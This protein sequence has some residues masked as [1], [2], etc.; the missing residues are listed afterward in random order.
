MLRTALSTLSARKRYVKKH[1]VK[2]KA[3]L[4]S[5][6]QSLLSITVLMSFLARLNKYLY[7]KMHCVFQWS[8]IDSQKE[9]LSLY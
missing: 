9:E 1:T 6:C 5:E 2:M 3:V 4:T 7:L 8:N